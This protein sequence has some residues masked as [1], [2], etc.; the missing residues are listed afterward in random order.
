MTTTVPLNKLILSPRNVRKT[1]VDEDI[2]S[3]ADSIGSK[4]LLQNLV[5]SQAPGDRGIFEVDAGGRRYRALQLLVTR[6]TIARNFPVPV[7]VVPREDATEASLAENLQKIAMNPADEVEAFEAIVERYAEGGITDRKEQIENCAR[8]FGV[9]FRHVEQRLRLAALAPDILTALREGRI[10][11][12]AAKA[13]A[14]HP[15]HKEQLRAFAAEEKKP[16][17]W[18]HA[19]QTIRDML[20]ARTYPTDHRAVIYVGLEAYQAA[21]GRIEADLFFGAEER[22]QLLDPAILDTLAAEKASAEAQR[23]AQE[24]GFLDG[25]VRPWH[26][27]IW[28]DFKAPKGFEVTYREPKGEDRAGAVAG[29][30]IEADGS[31]LKFSER[32]AVKAVPQA[33][34]GGHV[35]ETE[36]EREARLLK[37]RIERKALQLAMPPFAG[38][39]F[40]GRTYWP[41]TTSYIPAVD[42]DDQGN[43]VV[44]MLIT[45]PKEEVE[46]L[47]DEAEWALVDEEAIAAAE[48]KRQAAEAAA[49]ESVEGEGAAL[50]PDQ[51]PEAAPSAPAEME[52]AL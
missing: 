17:N 50:Q 28:A 34:G 33:P 1:N 10:K 27:H 30:E 22:E 16:E 48:A 13:Y 37:A 23:L 20:K 45:I 38:T 4:G 5:V 42:T 35:P 18:R 26:G 32:F 46:A 36:E 15:D 24:R 49:A 2:E 11:I 9:T 47:R 29:F 40:E 43:F 41:K 21:G 6:R 19:V 39:P 52:S 7:L 14:S 3:L 12:E 8:R 31:G 44:A 25:M 51:V